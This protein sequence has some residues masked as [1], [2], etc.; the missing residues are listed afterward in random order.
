MGELMVGTLMVL[1]VA[2]SGIAALPWTSAELRAS[3]RAHEAVG[4]AIRA[5]VS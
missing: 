5:V 4:S 3:V 1:T 2:G